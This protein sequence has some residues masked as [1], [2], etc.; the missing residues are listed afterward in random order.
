MAK[1]LVLNQ[2]NRALA[3]CSMERAFVL[4]FMQKSEM[5][6]NVEGQYLRTISEQYPMPSVIRLSKYI[7][8]PYKS[9]EL[10]RQNIFKRDDNEC[11]Y[12]GAKNDLT[13]DHVIPKSKGGKSNWTNLVAACKRCNSRKGHMSPEEAEMKLR[14]IPHKPTFIS[15]IKN[16]F[17]ASKEDWME[18]LE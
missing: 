18:Y 5:V 4:V 3:V 13:L 11:A 16:T 8:V 7:H 9:V 12:C 10:T 15:F 2:D 14:V 1:V 6:K 17:K